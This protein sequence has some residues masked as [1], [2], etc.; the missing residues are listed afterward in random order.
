MPPKKK[1]RQANLSSFF[2]APTPSPGVGDIDAL[3]VPDLSENTRETT[4]E[5]SSS[6]GCSSH[7]YISMIMFNFFKCTLFHP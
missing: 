7:K 3:I 1:F 6:R 4:Y 5:S 2:Q